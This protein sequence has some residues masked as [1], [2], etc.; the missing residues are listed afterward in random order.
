[1]RPQSV[2]YPGL[3]RMAVMTVVA[4]AL[5]AGLSACRSRKGQVRRKPP[6][7]EVVTIKPEYVEKLQEH[8]ESGLDADQ[9]A[10]VD[11]ALT[12]LGTPYRYGGQDKNGADCS[13][14]TMQVYR[15]ALGIA[16]PRTSRD[17]QKFCKSIRQ[18]S[19]EAGDLIFFT[20]GRDKTRVSHV[21]LYLGEGRFVHASG[22]KGVII[23]DMKE[24]YYSSNYHSSGHV[25]R[26]ADARR[27]KKEKVRELPR[28][29]M[30]RLETDPLV[31]EIDEEVEARIDSIYSSFLE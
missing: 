31:F 8:F 9:Q 7:Y 22:S 13:G 24:R 17:Q 25:I 4:V 30:P 6:K 15:R 3:W 2:H 27:G 14:L 12:W 20:T 29:D 16:I 18:S 11:E 21:G 26:P 19:L 10:L 5:A 1:M 23:S 28:E